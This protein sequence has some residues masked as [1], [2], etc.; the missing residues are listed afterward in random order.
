MLIA[1]HLSLLSLSAQEERYIQYT[2]NEGLKQNS[3]LDGESPVLI[4]REDR[5]GEVLIDYRDGILHELST[6]RGDNN[7]DALA[8]Y[9]DGALEELQSYRIDGTV[10]VVIYYEEGEITRIAVSDPDERQSEREGK[11]Q[12][13]PAREIVLERGMLVCE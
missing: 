6:R 8:I 5:S 4:Y 13:I 2:D 11:V 12:Y 7:P 1:L 9:N 3:M 10:A